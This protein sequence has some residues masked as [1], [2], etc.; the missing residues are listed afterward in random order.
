MK[1]S[2][3]SKRISERAKAQLA[4]VRSIIPPVPRRFRKQ[5]SLLDQTK[6]A[7]AMVPKITNET[8]AEHR[9]D[10]LRGARK[11]KY[12]L[13]HSKHRIVIVTSSIIAVALVTFFVTTMVELYNIQSTSPVIYRITQVIPFPVAKVNNTFLSYESYLFQLRRYMHYYSSQQQVDFSSESGKRQLEFYKPKA[14]EKI[15]RN[16][17]VNKLAERHHVTVT[18]SEVNDA[19]T[20]LRTQNMLQNNRDLESVTQRFYGWSLRDLERE[21]RQE[22]LAQKTASTLDIEAKKKADDAVGQAKS[23]VDFSALVAQ[24]SDDIATK[25][26]GGIYNDT[27]INTSSQSVAPVILREIMNMKAGDISRVTTATSF[28]IIKVLEVSADH[29]Y[30]V[31]HIQINFKP[32]ETFTKPIADKTKVRTFIKLERS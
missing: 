29:K 20:M 8:V 30:K 11:Y 23:G 31:A 25:N 7:F 19:I 26:N 3:D 22:L 6:Q 2:V 18:Q 21:L 15:T 17:Y 10:V 28:E 9:E 27:A 12:P 32:I 16:A 14:L 24:Y 1:S 4:N 5:S 13:E